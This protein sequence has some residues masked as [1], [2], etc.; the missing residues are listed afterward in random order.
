MDNNQKFISRWAPV[1]E[2]KIVYYVIDPLINLILVSLIACII[3]WLFPRTQ[4][5]LDYLVITIALLFLM[6]ISRSLIN[7]FSGEKRYNKIINK[8]Y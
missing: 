2:K 4:I 7:W 3:I 8:G 1:H 5:K 6:L